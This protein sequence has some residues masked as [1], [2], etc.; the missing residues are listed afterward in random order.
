MRGSMTEVSVSPNIGLIV[1]DRDQLM[2][3]DGERTEAAT[4]EWRDVRNP[5]IRDTVICQGAIGRG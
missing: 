2:W 1:G 4:G 3:I 5:A